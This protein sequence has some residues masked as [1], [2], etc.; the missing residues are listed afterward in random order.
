MSSHLTNVWKI[1]SSCTPR[2]WL[3]EK[4]DPK[5]V[6]DNWLVIL[7]TSLSS[8]KY[9][10]IIINFEEG[11]IPK[12]GPQGC[13]PPLSEEMSLYD[14]QYSPGTEPA[15]FKSA[16]WIKA[17]DSTRSKIFGASVNKRP[18]SSKSVVERMRRDSKLSTNSGWNAYTRRNKP[19]TLSK[20][21]LDSDDRN[22]LRFPALTL[23]RNQFGK[24][25]IIWM[26]PLATNINENKFVF[27]LMDIARK[28]LVPTL[29]PWEG[30]QSV[31][32]TITEK[33]STTSRA[34]GGDISAMD[35]N[36]KYY[37]SDQVFKCIS[38]IFQPIERENLK[39]SLDNLH[40]IEVILNTEQKLVGLHGVA[41][42]SSW[43]QFVET[44][45]Q[46]ILL[47]YLG[48]SGIIL[49]D[50][51]C[52]FF[53]DTK[54]SRAREVV[55][56][57]SMVGLPA[58]IEKQSDEENFFIFLQ[59]LFIRDV[60]SRE[61]KNVIAGIYSTVRALT[62]CVYPERFYPPDDYNSD[63]FC[64]RIYMILENCVDSP[65]FEPFCVKR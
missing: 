53:P 57:Y 43:T 51:S 44:I 24:D 63:I 32:Q 56:A 37:H 15:L 25:R 12:F 17:I 19:S 2:S 4:E 9:K 28:A 47:E 59:R 64:I 45:F 61:D 60:M 46:C 35:A 31:K 58:N 16:E 65:A 33:W 26:F 48:L 13:I 8:H 23:L 22:W 27:V 6:L 62:S 14:T 7:K 54:V 30:F 10:D 38:P 39:T 11:Q 50:D 52:L 34:V 42:G 18:L 55:D 36:F 5:R 21:I 41:S 29:S 49:G 40:N 1:G 3:Y 20:A